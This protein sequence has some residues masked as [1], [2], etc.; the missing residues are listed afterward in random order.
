MNRRAKLRVDEVHRKCSNGKPDIDQNQ[1]VLD[2]LRKGGFCRSR[3]KSSELTRISKNSA[4]KAIL[5]SKQDN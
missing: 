1:K 4:Q 3:R 5:R 2:A